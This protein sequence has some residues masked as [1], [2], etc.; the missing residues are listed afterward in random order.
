ML[1]VDLVGLII[2]E[3]IAEWNKKHNECCGGLK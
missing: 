3:H 2:K 1:G